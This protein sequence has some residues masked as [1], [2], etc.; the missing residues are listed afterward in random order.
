MPLPF[1][2]LALP[3]LLIVAAIPA[4][5]ADVTLDS[6]VLATGPTGKITFKHLVLTDLN[7][8]QS[9]AASLFSGALPR[10][11][12]G[13]LLER[14]TA[15]KLEIP[16]TD[17]VAE[18]GARYT[19]HDIEA[20]NIA[21]GGADRLSLASVDGV[22]P[23]DSGDT[24]IHSGKLSLQAVSLP[25]LAAALRGG[26]IGLAAFRFTRLDWDGGDI[27]A[28]DKGTAAGEEGGNRIVLRAG[29]AHVDQ[30]LDKDGAPLAGAAEFSG[31]SLKMPPQSK[32]GTTLAAFGY[33]EIDGIAQFKGGYDAAA[34][35]YKLADYSIDLQKIGKVA[36]SGQFSGVEKSAFI[37]DRKTREAALRA[38]TVD[39][40]QIAVT[41]SGL[42]DK[43]V[44]FV[45][46]S[47]G[48]TPEAVKAEWRGIVSQAPLLFSGAPAIDVAAK[49]VDRFIANP[50]TLA[51]RAKGKDAPLKVGDMA[52]VEDPIAFLDRL[53]VESVPQAAIPAQPAVPAQ[54]IKP[55]QPAVPAPPAIPASP[56]KP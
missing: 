22:L 19:M 40:A 20:D 8:S 1:R 50:K 14:M 34:K 24:K 35:T 46:L 54:P 48:R 27:S 7:L 3:A 9:E 51:L 39:W 56:A 33:D 18:N 43:V 25:G 47:Q 4:R 29:A 30:T 55:A 11:E 53:D 17:V 41:N 28:V 49:A 52:H 44:A 45:S 15:K 6:A 5:A 37:G 10:E 16:E 2:A 23:D 26:D 21:R 38:A 32:A 36:F 12:A 31:L 13:A 42:F